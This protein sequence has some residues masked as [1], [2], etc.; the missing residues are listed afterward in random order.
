MPEQPIKLFASRAERFPEPDAKDVVERVLRAGLA[1]V[2]L[3]GGP[4]DELL[5]L[6]M[7]PAV[8][9]RRDEWLKDLADVVEQLE[10]RVEGFKPENLAGNEAFV[11]ATL[12][13]TRIALS[14]HQHE[15]RV[16]LRNALLNIAWGKTAEEDRHQ[17]LLTAIEAFTMS[18]VKVLQ[19]LWTGRGSV[20]LVPPTTNYG[21]AIQTA[22][23]ELRVENDFLQH[24][25]NDLRN[26]G[27]SNL[28]GPN[29]AHPQHPAITNFGIAF[30][31][32]VSTPDT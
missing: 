26:R 4:V 15:K 10:K 18:H 23:P 14:T 11:S 27:F 32:F 13:A 5:S 25:M 29:A 16:L 22:L 8:E 1:G 28:S 2:P 19:F 12:Y 9:K 20:A 31:R 17:V 30:L 6:V 3:V 24:I 21:Q 7:V